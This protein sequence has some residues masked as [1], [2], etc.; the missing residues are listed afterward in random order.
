MQWPQPTCSQLQKWSQSSTLPCTHG[1]V[2]GS[3]HFLR[4][5]PTDFLEFIFTSSLLHIPFVYVIVQ[6]NGESLDSKARL[7]GLES[8]V[9]H[10][11]VMHPWKGMQLL[12]ASNS[13][14]A[15]QGSWCYLLCSTVWRT[16]W[17]SD[18]LRS[19]LG[20]NQPQYKNQLLLTYHL[21]FSYSTL[22]FHLYDSLIN[23]YRP[24][25]AKV[26]L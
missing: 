1:F 16:Q 20:M 24:D 3:H 2:M 21:P 22:Y 8:Q 10:Q 13:S 4:K 6:H 11:L 17:I 5:T 14:L 26:F 18:V 7:G 25:F 9:L 23:V 12:C 19:V 15:K